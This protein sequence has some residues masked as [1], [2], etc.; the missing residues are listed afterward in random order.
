MQKKSTIL[1]TDTQLHCCIS[2]EI[3]IEVWKKDYCDYAG[4]IIS[5]SDEEIKVED[6]YFLREFCVIKTKQNILKR[7]V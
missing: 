1:T 7:V 4:K 6:G 5:F 3:N 2:N